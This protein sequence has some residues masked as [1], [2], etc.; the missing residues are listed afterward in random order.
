MAKQCFDI[1][2]WRHHSADG[3]WEAQALLCRGEVMVSEHIA[4]GV[5]TCSWMA[6]EKVELERM[7]EVQRSLP[8]FNGHLEVTIV[9]AQQLRAGRRRRRGVGRLTCCFHPAAE[10]SA[11]PYAVAWLKVSTNARP[12][13]LQGEGCS[14]DSGGRQ[15]WRG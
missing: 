4:W 13:V 2:F 1:A 8:A 12:W 3:V 11:N 14:S 15:V 7:L 10:A 6:W 9:A 5:V